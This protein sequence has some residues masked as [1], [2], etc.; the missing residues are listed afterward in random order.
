M[1]I[2]RQNEARR[3]SEYQGESAKT[4][5]RRLFSIQ[6]RYEIS[7]RRRLGFIW[8]KVTAPTIIPA[9]SIEKMTPYAPT[10]RWK[11]LRTSFGVRT[12]IGAHWNMSTNANSVMVTHSHGMAVT[13][14][15]RA[16]ISRSVPTD[17]ARSAARGLVAKTN[18]N[19][20]RYENALK[21]KTT[22][23]PAK[24]YIRPANV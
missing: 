17:S 6:I 10:L 19:E 2:P 24:P 22:V 9:P 3:A 11:W 21:P 16:Q 1:Q 18:P 20:I 8:P 4:T 14:R 23:E 7:P 13:Y 12:W 15:I 5:I